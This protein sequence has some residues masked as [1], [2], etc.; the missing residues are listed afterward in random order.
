MRLEGASTSLGRAVRVVATS[1]LMVGGVWQ[2]AAK[3]ALPGQNSK[4]AF[5]EF[6]SWENRRKRERRAGLPIGE[7]T[8]TTLKQ[9]TLDIATPRVAALCV[10]RYRFLFEAQPSCTA[11]KQ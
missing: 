8:E 4:I 11:T 6:S 7:A 2:D 1:F 5:V 10:V 9:A 3:V